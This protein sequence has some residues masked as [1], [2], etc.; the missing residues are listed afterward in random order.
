MDLFCYLCFVF[1]CHTVLSVPCSLVVTCFF[2]FLVNYVF[3]CFCHFP[4]WC[5]GSC[6]VFDCIGSDLCLLPNF[7]II[8]CLFTPRPP[9]TSISGILSFRIHF[10]QKS[11][12]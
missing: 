4:I 11:E 6:V 1:V 10:S 8:D 5:S 9:I 3:L 7:G 2:D 12:I